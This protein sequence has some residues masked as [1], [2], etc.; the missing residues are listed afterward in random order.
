MRANRVSRADSVGSGR[1]CAGVLILLV[2]LLASTAASATEGSVDAHQWLERMTRAARELN[3]DGI[4]AYRNGSQ[5]ESMR[6]IHR[7]GPDGERSRLVSLS[8]NKREVLRDREQVICILPDD[9]SVLVA[10]TRPPELFTSALLS[11]RAGFADHYTLST[12]GGDRVAGRSTE[13]ITLQPKDEFRYGY[14]LWV[15]QESGLLLKSD[16]MGAG[17]M[18]LEQFIYTSINL[19]TEVPD[20]LLEPGL[21]GRALTWHTGEQQIPARSPETTSGWQVTWL[22]EGFMMSD[23]AKDPVPTSR[24]PVEQMVYTDGLASLSVFI[25]RLDAASEPLDGLSA[26]GALNAFGR[27]VD[28]HQITAVGEVPLQTV[29]AVAKSVVRK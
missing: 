18:P 15:D 27:L 17:M 29:E 8:G 9:Q 24:T 3:Y 25:E 26:M 2:A 22:P 12:A 20:S 16:L 11:T 5:M 21:S 7:G 6:I 28:G 4:F 1:G 23:H 19:L 14:R 13:V 10:K